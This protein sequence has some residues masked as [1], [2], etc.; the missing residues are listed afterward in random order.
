VLVHVVLVRVMQMTVM[1]IV[2]VVVVVDRRM[3][4]IRTVLMRVIL[5]VGKITAH[6]S[7]SL[8]Q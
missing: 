7:V 2:H 3:S 5:V 4:A 1:E 6:S 8:L